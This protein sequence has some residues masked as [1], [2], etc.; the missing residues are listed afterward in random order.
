MPV[1]RHI[2]DELSP[3]YNV[4]HHSMNAHTGNHGNAN[5]RAGSI[6]NMAQADGSLHNL[7]KVKS[8]SKLVSTQFHDHKPVLKCSFRKM[9]LKKTC[10]YP[11]I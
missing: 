5:K 2:Q 3:R 6:S 4:T 10:C 8:Q 1:R 7:T 11:Y 9:I